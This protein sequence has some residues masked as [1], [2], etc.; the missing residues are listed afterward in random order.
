VP[1]K[2][3]RIL[4]YLPST[5]RAVPRPTALYSVTDAF[6][7]ELQAA[8]NSLAAVMQAH[9][10]DHADL[11]AELFADLPQFAALYG[12]GPRDDEE[13]EEFRAHLKRYVRTFIEGTVTVQGVLR[14]AA[15]A[16][17]L[18][19]ADRPEELDR[20]WQ[21]PG[22]TL[23]T[24]RARLDDAAA[25][26]FGAAPLTAAGAD[27]RP[28]AVTGTADLSAGVDI[29]QAPNLVL[30]VDGE[31]PVTI[32][33]STVPHP[34]AATAADVGAAIAAS[35]STAVADAPGGRL[36]LRS[37]T[38]G[39]SSSL[40]VE[41]VD[42]DAAPAL[43]GLPA[44]RA[45]GH[46]ATAAAVAGR[47]DLS[48]GVDLDPLR[49]LRIRVDAT[50]EAEIDLRGAGPAHASLDDLRSR[51]NAALG[52]DAAAAD[53]S[54]VVLRSPTEGA[55]GSVELLVPAAQ[56]ATALVF[57]DGPRFASGTDEQPA[58]LVGH[59]VSAG[60][61]L[62]DASHLA[63]SVD[64][65]PS[66]TADCA[67]ADPAATRPGEVVERLNA[68]LGPVAG[69]DGRSITISSLTS[70]PDA[71][72]AVEPPDER[73]ATELILG[74]GPRSFAG[75]DE[76]T[77]RLTGPS[78]P[79]DL[80]AQSVVR[81]AIDD[82]PPR[83]V[84]LR[85]EAA[86]AGA[87]TPDELAH[88]IVDAFGSSVAAVDG[89]TLVVASTTEGAAGRVAVEPLDETVVRRFVTRAVVR[90]EAAETLL[91][92]LQAEAEGEPARPAVVDGA[93]DLSHGVDLRAGGWLRLAVDGGP[94][95][96]IFVAGARAR[97][98][99]LD[100]ITVAIN[101]AVAPAVVAHAVE[102]RLRLV[103]PTV[104]ASGSL[105][106]APPTAEDALQL[107]GF[108]A[109]T[110][111][112]HD[113]VTV[114]FLGTVDLAPNVDLSGAE[115]VRLK[116]DGNEQEVDC[117]GAD[118][119]HTRVDEIVDA[120]NNAFG[121]R[122][123]NV[124]GP[125]IRIQ[126]PTAGAA[127]VVE[128]LAPA[129]GADAAPL[130]FGITPPRAYHG[131]DAQP[132]RIVGAVDLSGGLALADRRFLRITADAGPA[133]AVDLGAGAA[134]PAN[135][136][137][138]EVIA[139]VEATAPGV[140]SRDDGHLVLASPTAG[141]GGRLTLEPYTS[142]DARSAL[143]GGASSEAHGSDGEPATITGSVDLLRPVDL[144]RRST[145]VL[146]FD[147][148]RPT[149]V[150]VAGATPAT[151][152]LDEV[153]SILNAR[154]PG[155]AAATDDDRLRLQWTGERLEV[156]PSRLLEVI[157]YPPQSQV[158]APVR[159]SHGGTWTIDDN[160]AAE[161]EAEIELLAVRGIA[162][163]G[164]AN[165][166][167]AVELRVL[168]AID[169]GGRLLLRPTEDGAVEATV[170]SPS[171]STAR[172]PPEAILIRSTGP[173][174]GPD[175]L[176]IVRGRSEWRYLECV[177]T[178]YDQAHFDA[179]AFS[180]GPCTE[181]G[182]FDASSWG[183][184]PDAPIKA[185]FG[186]AAALPEDSVEV[187]VR[188]TKHAPGSFAV[189]LPAELPPR[190]GARFGD[191]RF[192]SGDQV[193]QYAGAVTEPTGD[194]KDLAVLVQSSKLIDGR[195]VD[196][197]PLGWSAVT[198]P[199]RRPQRLTIGAPGARA[200][201]YVREE[202]VPGFIELEAREDGPQGTSI[203]VTAPR[204]G[205]AEFDVT[206][207]FEAGRFESARDVVRGR[208]LSASADD[209]LRPGPIGV[210]E[211]KA[212]GIH[213]AVRRERTVFATSDDDN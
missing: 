73:D 70:G 199:F 80:R 34:D 58:R 59:D 106:L 196:T 96:N 33:L 145:L 52:I 194:K 209:L 160:G 200:A 97:A 9:W 41:D 179:D 43:L 202:D 21:R 4:T 16:L 89:G 165:V 197:V 15:E 130:I 84:D 195:H 5:F 140:A 81:I 132:A 188:W 205:P 190:F 207:S 171:G 105:V 125:R 151:T 182:V 13:I 177:G 162:A 17:G 40:S 27:A 69:Y 66:V 153:V 20:W 141:A 22:E 29:R 146:A 45:R 198:L 139:A 76:L 204:S 54:S 44:R 64:G 104:G 172:V 18:T 30:A 154:F 14:I 85:A 56:D 117:A 50:H 6:G 135:P 120:I 127:G 11:F 161:A 112:G 170:T 158:E 175:P 187:S 123:A 203:V 115:R 61:D 3:D 31:A 93:A 42:G 143:L 37:P 210:L 38:E 67:G 1:T 149:E 103:S 159:L 49:Y 157:E 110:A 28:A 176:L 82:G 74:I 91:G 114:S 36:R 8:E 102:G 98:A 47:A 77:A 180:G 108:S 208:P 26:V 79:V 100:T 111:R 178:R 138:D 71:A 173:D 25:I 206:V 72:I 184:V 63:V 53:G 147:G 211:A 181:I 183:T 144:S 24:R 12:L 134:N 119:A 150:D 136:S 189:N 124:E 32:D 7:G 113:A 94:A 174:G 185:V 186:D 201:L 193:E 75:A 122:Y 118:P 39:A 78:E 83:D 131:S 192:G 156:L 46:A 86:A 101:E 87:V 10:V 133:V 148:G 2:T 128:F 166:S 68:A 19:I 90:G 88:A 212:A 51:I 99:T 163:P 155:L 116:I 35:A 152:F 109:G 23:T 62:R 137:L 191:G 95:Q 55:A 213:A 121:T 164:I 57:G 129:G 169:A 107:V 168:T 65:A 92:V 126:S 60:L 167:A 142:R 48:A